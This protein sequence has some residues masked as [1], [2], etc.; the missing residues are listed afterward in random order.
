M[1][2]SK[3]KEHTLDVVQCL[4]IFSAVLEAIKEE[5]R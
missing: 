3:Q 1:L 2:E 4:S 5:D